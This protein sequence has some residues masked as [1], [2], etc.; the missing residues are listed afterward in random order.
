VVGV[1][2]LVGWSPIAFTSATALGVL[3][4]LLAAASYSAAGVYTKRRLAGAPASTL[5]LGQQLAAGVWLVAPAL[6]RL[7]Q[8][9]PTPAALWALAGLAVLSTAL[10]YPLYFYLIAHVGPTKASSV[11]YVVPVFGMAWGALF[12]GE[13]ITGGMVAGFLCI[14][15]SMALVTGAWKGRLS[16]LSRVPLDVTR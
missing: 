5:A 3:A 10:A 8:A 12:L 7:P 14:A 16:L 9:H 11:T 2:V 1:T 6:V 13:P 4:M 15:G